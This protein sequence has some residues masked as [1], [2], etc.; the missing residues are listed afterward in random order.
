MLES[1][2][3]WIPWLREQSA[4]TVAAYAHARVLPADPRPYREIDRRRRRIARAQQAA[5]LRGSEP[6]AAAGL[7]LQPISLADVAREAGHS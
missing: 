7:R 4:P 1:I 5:A 3:A 6:T 2:E